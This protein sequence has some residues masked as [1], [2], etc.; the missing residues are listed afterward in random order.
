[1]AVNGK[2]YVK[3]N[4]GNINEF[5]VPVIDSNAVHKSGNETIEDTKTFTGTIITANNAALRRNDASGF[6]QLGFTTVLNGGR[7]NLFG[8]D[9]TSDPGSFAL[10]TGDGTNAKTLKG[11]TAGV[12]SWDGEITISGD[13]GTIEN[14]ALLITG[15]R[16]N[17][18]LALQATNATKGTAPSAII[19]SGI[20]FYGSVH[21]K[22]Q[23]RYALIENTISTAN[24]NTLKLV[25]YNP[26][27]AENTGNCIISVNVDNAGNAYTYAPT[28]DTG[29]NST[30]IATTAFVKAQGYTTA[31]GHTHSY[32]PLSGGTLTGTLSQSCAGPA[33]NCYDTD[34]TKG[35]NPSSTHWIGSLT[36]CDKT[37]NNGVNYRG[38]ILETCVTAAGETQ[39]YLRAYNWKASTST[40]SH[41]AI[42]YPQ[43]GTPYTYAPTPATADNSTKIATTAFVKAQ[44]YTTAS[45]H[46]HSYLPLSGGTLTGKLTMSREDSVIYLND[47]GFTK[48]TTP[49]SIN[50][51]GEIIGADKNGG[52]TIA[53]R[54]GA[55]Q[56][57]VNT[58]GNSC[59]EISTY[60]NTSG[61]SS[62]GAMIRVW[63]IKGSA[64][65]SYVTLVNA[66]PPAGDNSAK[67][68]TTGWVTS[69]FSK[70]GHTHSYI[71]TSGGSLSGV[72]ESTGANT[73]F[74]VTNGTT[75]QCSL[76]RGSTYVGLYDPV[77]SQWVTRV[78]ESKAYIHYGTVSAV[79]DKRN[80]ENIVDITDDILNA[81]GEVE[82]KQFNFKNIVNNK[83]NIGLIAQ[84]VEEVF[85]KNNL[86]A[87]N[88]PF[89][90]HEIWEQDGEHESSGDQY[91]I[92]YTEALCMEAA[93]Q[94]RRA[95]RAEARITEL[96]NQM[97]MVLEKLELS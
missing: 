30:K 11:T 27:S 90:E 18:G 37:G 57:Y 46:T 63:A 2:I 72:I 77:N 20:E 85:N 64:S 55:L 81:W 60:E 65:S 24:L 96:E 4:S 68:P 73:G 43:D 49:S 61:S 35:T 6:L 17:Y 45:G 76:L 89:F 79:S 5:N 58:S 34:L 22:Y 80:K 1:M 69:N 50:Y 12:L 44:G 39:V 52:A 40:E 29:D 59:T 82:W 14:T 70:S 8:K 75:K 91:Y 31:S 93:Y 42:C 13:H 41:M 53:N 54:L 97:K 84:D 95:E 9:Y 48:G 71:P 88:Y 10:M 83:I 51:I 25:A 94:R 87:E 92:H 23:N 7:L 38:G 78:A 3:D 33:Y 86:N 15:A 32:L 56:F 16:Q 62:N 26:T 28:P 67:V 66:T 47:T 74:K 19:N 21:T 36:F